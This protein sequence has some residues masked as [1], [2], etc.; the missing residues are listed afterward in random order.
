MSPLHVVQ[1]SDTHLSPT[2]PWISANFDAITGIVSEVRPDL[3]VNTGDISFDGADLEGDLAFA[4]ARHAALGCPVRAIP[5]NHDVGDNPW[6][7]RSEPQSITATRLERYRRHFGDDYWRVDA[8]RWLLIGLNVQLFGSGLVAEAEQWVFVAAAATL[9]GSRPIA[10]FVHKPL[11]EEDP[12][13]TDVNHRFVP[14]EHRHRLMAM[15]GPGLRVVASG[16]VHQHRHRRFGAVD[17]W[18]VPST[19]F[20]FSDHRQPRLGTKRV[21][22][23]DLVFDGDEVAARIVEPPELTNHDID[24]FEALPRG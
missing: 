4:R 10:L 17:H 11:F 1:V 23:A 3:V 13:E 8:G 16:H 2:R 24:E 15:L 19:A 14:P 18:W 22:Y 12:G 20:V 5:G 7:A 6:R 9:A 21:G